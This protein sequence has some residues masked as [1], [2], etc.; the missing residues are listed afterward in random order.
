MRKIFTAL[1]VIFV[2]FAS[3]CIG[4][5]AGGNETVNSPDQAAKAAQD[6]GDSVGDLSSAIS[7]VDKDLSG[8]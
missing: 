4:A 7:D 6:V 8:K 5:G 1:L 3:G 2:I